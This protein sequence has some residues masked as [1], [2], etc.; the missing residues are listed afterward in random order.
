LVAVE[1][2]APRTGENPGCSAAW[3]RV[4]KTISQ[5]QATEAALGKLGARDITEE[6]AEQVLNNSYVIVRNLRGR[7]ARR[8]P[9]ARRTLIGHTDGGRTLTLVIE[10]TDEPTS[11]LIITGWTAT[12]R[13]RKILK[14]KA[15]R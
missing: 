14:K 12:E 13:E 10:E 7:A 1:E 15:E 5:I 8:Q 4:A 9:S 2:S 3:S 6:E 11:W